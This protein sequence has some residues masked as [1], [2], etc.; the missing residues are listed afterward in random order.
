MIELYPQQKFNFKCDPEIECFN[1]CCQDLQQ[2][3]T[4]YDIVRLKQHFKVSSSDFLKQYTRSF[5][6]PETGL[7]VIVLKTKSN[8]DLHCIFVSDS[9]CQVY[10]DRPASCRYYPIARLVSR[11][12][13]TGKK[14]ASYMLIKEAHCK[15]HYA[16]HQQTLE[17]WTK[18][19]ELSDYDLYNDRMLDLIAAKNNAGIRLLSEHQRNF[20]YMCCY[21]I[22]SFQDYAE[23][24]GLATPKMIRRD[25]ITEDIEWLD[26]A[27]TWLEKEIISASL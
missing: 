7:P 1:S 16:K 5:I 9:G 27:L 6:G 26:F 21:D 15:G 8:L 23:T 20:F 3:L 18:S 14:T 25:S 4:P 17:K 12:R 11:S 13:G 10:N 2:I 19:Q 22:D 24:K